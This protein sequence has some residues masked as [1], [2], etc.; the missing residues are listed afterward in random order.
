[1]IDYGLGE[2]VAQL[3]AAYGGPLPAGNLSYEPDGLGQ[4]GTKTVVTDEAGK[5]KVMSLRNIARTAPYGHNGFFPTL[6][7]IVHF[8]N[9]REL[10][11]P[12]VSWPGE[13]EWPDPEVNL[14]INF[15]E[16]GDLGLTF[17]EEQKIVLFLETLTDE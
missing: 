12:N 15:A 13:P 5:F 9:T 6:Y 3:E 8:Y 17:D 1:M 10:V 16:L 2:M 7:S 4:G 11:F 14:N